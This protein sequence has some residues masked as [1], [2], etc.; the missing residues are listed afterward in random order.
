VMEMCWQDD[1]D[2]RPS[3]QEV[4]VAITKLIPK[5]VEA[6]KTFNAPGS[7]NYSIDDDDVIPF[8]GNAKTNDQDYLE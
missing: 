3:F 7:G 1:P 4:C 8:Y 2:N 6:D 5:T